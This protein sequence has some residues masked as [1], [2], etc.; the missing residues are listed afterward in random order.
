MSS[1]DKN[2]SA[3]CFRKIATDVTNLTTPMELYGYP[4]F[5][6]FMNRQDQPTGELIAVFVLEEHSPMVKQI[7]GYAVKKLGT[8]G[9]VQVGHVLLDLL[10][11]GKIES[12]VVEKAFLPGLQWS[13]MLAENYADTDVRSL[14]A[15]ILETPAFS[16][17]GRRYLSDQVLTGKAKTQ[18]EEMRAWGEI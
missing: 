8:K 1:M 17:R 11:R 5:Q 13:H 6:E 9:F 15:R 14:I 2:S 7:A 12:G 18:V 10:A 16:E 4:C 3:E